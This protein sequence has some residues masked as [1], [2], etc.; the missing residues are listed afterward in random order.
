MKSNLLF[1][2]VAF[3]LLF[4]QT[5]AAFA[6]RNATLSGTVSDP[7]L[8][9]KL[10]GANVYLENTGIGSITDVNGNYVITGIPPGDYTL[11]VSYIGY[12]S[13]SEPMELNAGE[14]IQRDMELQFSGGVD[15]EEV[16]ITVQAI[17]QLKAINQQLRSDDI[18]NVV[19]S[20]RIRELPDANAA[21]ALGRLPGV[22][23]K[24]SGGEGNQVVIR[25]MS[26]KY[27]KVMVDGVDLAG[28]SSYDRSI[29]L[30][31]ISA[32][33]L[34][35]IEVIKSARAD[36]DGDF[37]GGAVNFKLRSAQE[38]FHAEALAQGTYNNLKS[39]FGNYNFM[40]S[41]S[42]R[43]F[44][45]K[46]G[47]F[48][49]GQMEKQNRSANIRNVSTYTKYRGL[50][51]NGFT[52][53]SLTLQD[54]LR[55]IERYNATLVFDYKLNN[56]S[57]SFKNFYSKRNSN[58]EF[59][60]ERFPSSVAS[61]KDVSVNV[62]DISMQQTLYNN[63]LSYD[64]QFGS[65]KVEAAAAHAYT[66][67][68]NP[69]DLSFNFRQSETVDGSPVTENFPE[70]G[71]YP[72]DAVDYSNADYRFLRFNNITF[73]PNNTEHRQIQGE[74]NLEWAFNISGMVS[75]KLKAG[76]KYK[77]QERSYEYDNWTGNFGAAG[78]ELGR[79]Y[80]DDYPELFEPG[81][82][83]ETTREI[84]Y[85]YFVDPGIQPDQFLDGSYGEFL[86][87]VD[88]AKLHHITDYMMFD[89][90]AIEENQQKDVVMHN[91]YLERTFDYFGNEDYSAAYLMGTF[92]I[93]RMVTLIPGVRFEQN[94]TEYTGT[95]GRSDRSGPNYYR[96]VD[97][98]DTTVFRE[99]TFF[100]P[101][102][103][104]KL[105][106]LKWLQFHLAYTHTLQRPS[107]GLIIPRE[108]KNDGGAGGFVINNT[109]LVPELSKNFDFVTSFHG[110]K[111]GLFSINLFTKQ[112]ENKIF[113]DY[114]KPV[115]D[116]WEEFEGIEE[117]E[118]GYQYVWHY[119]DTSGVDLKGIELD[120]QTSFWYLP[121]FLKGF[122]FNVNYTYIKSQAVYPDG[123]SEEVIDFETFESYFVNHDTIYTDRLIDQ[124]AHILNLSLG[125]DIKGFSIRAS[126]RYQDNIF[127]G[128]AFN[129]ENRSFTG[130]YLRFD[131]SATQKLPY[132]IVIFTNLNNINN[133]QDL[134]Y[135]N[136]SAA[137]Q[138]P[139]R[140]ENY[141]MTV[142]LGLRWNFSIDK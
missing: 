79:D 96:Y 60:S 86:P 44:D 135:N 80:Q 58:N 108:D 33:S 67:S 126:M 57:L 18:K 54:E 53:S 99:N 93:G 55:T 40:G 36:M 1:S 4:A 111:L 19:S 64:Q 38:G 7:A 136:G 14:T 35:G 100:L 138:F 124:P 73:T 77:H 75:A 97:A 98:R 16:T 31:G 132:G 125:Y 69:T 105:K 74:L 92:N 8:N 25:G 32:Y 101:N 21:E 127:R 41:V 56:G 61:S 84:Y 123:T 52:H 109:Q 29:S 130:S 137:Q 88:L 119:N 71:I 107:Y 94:K 9:E 118:Q 110:N 103:H 65:I 47:V 140:L 129:I 112:I 17:G 89:Y 23:L 10:I 95:K 139:T 12:E 87:R 34:D 42:N 27:V 122:V 20:D 134:N 85:T 37:V 81:D 6:Q 141:G 90:Y 2:I 120:W 72:D 106:P 83:H 128:T 24:R 131:L 68:D 116:K 70:G 5:A 48:A 13:I 62:R 39:D 3:I 115:G 15:L 76:G 50:E 22:S 51:D 104:L 49:M 142:D 30:G 91:A 114:Q 113:A 63:N 43:F 59:Y 102:V 121:G 28:S 117:I 66:K 82:I 11:H 26:P 78:N 46:L 133:A 45:S